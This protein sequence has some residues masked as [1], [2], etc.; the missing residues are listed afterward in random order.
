M[1]IILRLLPFILFSAIS[2]H[3]STDIYRCKDKQGNLVFQ[4]KACNDG[5]VTGTG[6]EHRAWRELRALTADGISVHKELRADVASIKQCKTDMRLING[7]LDGMRQ[8]MQRLSGSSPLL[9]KSYQDLYQCMHC[10]TSAESFCHT[11][12]KI[13]NEAMKSLIQT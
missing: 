13:L 9:Y 4:Q 10:K 5:Q 3:G 1:R 7:K 2:V 6:S 12:D 11:S 8:R